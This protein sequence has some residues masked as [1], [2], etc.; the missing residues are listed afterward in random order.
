M[1]VSGWEYKQ[2]DDRQISFMASRG[3]GPLFAN[4]KKLKKAGH[5]LVILNPQELVEGVFRSSKMDKV[6]P[7]VFDLDTRRFRS[8]GA[9]PTPQ[10]RG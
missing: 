6:M 1:N 2:L 9:K 4:T 5:K 3:I 7:I 8:C 10:A